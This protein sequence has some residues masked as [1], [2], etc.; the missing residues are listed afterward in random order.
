MKDNSLMYVVV[1]MC[2]LVFTV[3]TLYIFLF[4][5]IISRCTLPN[6]VTSIL[7]CRLAITSFGLAVMLAGRY[8]YFVFLKKIDTFSET[9][10]LKMCVYIY[11]VDNSRYYIT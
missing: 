4:R 3:L 5:H 9:F 1:C 10:L 7:L 6:K 8:V 11:V 2:A